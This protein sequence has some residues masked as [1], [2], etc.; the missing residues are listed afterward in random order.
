[1]NTISIIFGAISVA[2]LTGGITA[3]I[4]TVSKYN[5]AK[6]LFGSTIFILIGAVGLFLCLAI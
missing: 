4:P 2:F 5:D 1:M 6:N 3:Y